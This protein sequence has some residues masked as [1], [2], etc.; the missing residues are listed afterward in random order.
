[1]HPL[2][3]KHRQHHYPIINQPLINHLAINHSLALNLPSSH[4]RPST[5]PAQCS[6]GCGERA[7]FPWES[8]M[9]VRLGVAERFPSSISR[10]RSQQL[11]K[12]VTTATTQEHVQDLQNLY[13]CLLVCSFFPT[14]FHKHLNC[15]LEPPYPHRDTCM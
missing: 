7:S 2:V 12:P 3:I 11:N 14:F 13:V 9:K 5:S 6:I 4:G 8:C 10:L 1:M 15:V